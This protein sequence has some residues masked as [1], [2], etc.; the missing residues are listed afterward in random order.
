MN[1]S[2]WVYRLFD[3][4]EE[5][6]LEEVEKILAQEHQPTRMRLS[7]IRP[8][9]IQFKNPPVAV[10]LGEQ[11]VKIGRQTF[12]AQF[13]GKIYDLGVIGIIMRLPLQEGTAFGELQNIAVELYNSDEIEQVFFWQL[14][15]IR[16]TLS[17]ALVKEAYSGFVED[18]TVYYFREWDPALDPTQLLLAEREPVSEQVR[19]ETMRNSF[20]YGPDDLTVITWDSALVYDSTGST[21]I[22]D[23]LEFANAQLL[24]LR[25]YDNLLTGELEKMYDAIEEAEKVISFRRLG[26]YRRI[27]NQLMELI[28]DVT[29]ITERIDNSLKVTEDV[30]YARIYGAALSIFRTRAWAESIDRK[31]SIISQSYT[32]LSNRI[33]NQ[34]SELLELAIILLILLEVILG[35][36]GVIK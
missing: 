30:F 16:K 21:D 2:I 17:A 33:I 15:S 11:K 18:F 10:E 25:Y 34:R 24:E 20:S 32:M 14:D 13:T 7:R 36:L 9:S 31:I 29:E 26:H 22:P 19:R 3:V 1:N 5:I 35:T 8:K 12:K 6:N 4:A 27:M 23:L 28:A